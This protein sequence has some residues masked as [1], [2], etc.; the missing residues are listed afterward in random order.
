MALP[1]Q[2]LVERFL[3]RPIFLRPF[4]CNHCQVR[5]YRFSLQSPDGRRLGAANPSESFI[6]SRRSAEFEELVD[7]LREAERRLGDSK[8]KPVDPAI[9]RKLG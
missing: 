2:T 1:A 6:K 5:F 7:S 9:R 3:A 4:L 8:A